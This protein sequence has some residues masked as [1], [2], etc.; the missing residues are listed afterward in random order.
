MNNPR[1]YIIRGIPGSGKTTYGNSLG[2]YCFN[3]NDQYSISGGIYE[4]DDCLSKPAS[5]LCL[6]LCNMIMIHKKDI[7][8]CEVFLHIS[9]MYDYIKR[10]TMNSY[11]IVIVDCLCDLNDSFESNLHQV[12]M[13]KIQNMYNSFYQFPELVEL[14]DNDEHKNVINKSNYQY[15]TYN[16]KENS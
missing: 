1:L 9:D 13:Y 5:I 4:Y 6:S 8:I 12:P 2:C 10:A 7:A 11:D 14:C 3:P 15:F 16:K